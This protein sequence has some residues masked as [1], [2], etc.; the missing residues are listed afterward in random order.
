M[1]ALD[2]E[3]LSHSTQAGV[4]NT[5]SSGEFNETEADRADMGRFGN[6][7]RLRRSLNSR[8]VAFF[9]IMTI[10][11]WAYVF[12]GASLGLSSAGTADTITVYMSAAVLYSTIVVSMAEL[13]SM[14]PL[15]GGPY[16]WVY[17]LASPRYESQP[18]A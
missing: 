12:N 2:H 10:S 4:P 14:V 6:P 5:D 16:H 8:T 15:A 9:M 17:M 18:P 11:S 13:A 7:Q 3:K 1:A